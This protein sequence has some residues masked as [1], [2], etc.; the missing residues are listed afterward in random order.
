MK[1]K[2][3]KIYATEQSDFPD[4]HKLRLNE[5]EHK[6]VAFD[7]KLAFAEKLLREQAL[8]QMDRGENLNDEQKSEPTEKKL[9][10]PHTEFNEALFQAQEYLCSDHWQDKKIEIIDVPEENVT[11]RTRYVLIVRAVLL[12][13]LPFCRKKSIIRRKIIHAEEQQHYNRKV[14][15]A[16]I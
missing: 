6:R 11:R 9:L 16:C 12:Q 14:F 15:L 8:Q 7:R 4:Q 1:W 2:E 13:Q 10:N 3:E 5:E